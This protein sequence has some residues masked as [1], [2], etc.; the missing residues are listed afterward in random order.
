MKEMKKIEN[1]DAIASALEYVDVELHRARRAVLN[2]RR[3]QAEEAIINL[4]SAVAAVAAIMPAPSLEQ[5]E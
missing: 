1:K 3:S 5:G 4:K 2:D